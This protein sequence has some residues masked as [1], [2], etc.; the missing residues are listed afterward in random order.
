MILR[1]G[2]M[3][4]AERVPEDEVGVVD[5]VVGALG[6]PV[7]RPCEGEP[8]KDCM[9]DARL[10]VILYLTCSIVLEH[11]RGTRAP[12]LSAWFTAPLHS[13]HS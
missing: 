1:G 7:G 11:G 6:D 8:E 5:V 12:R 3:R 10:Y 4:D 9:T 2:E 13:S